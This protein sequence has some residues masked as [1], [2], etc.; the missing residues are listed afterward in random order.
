MACK[1]FAVKI[2]FAWVW[3]SGTLADK[4]KW[5]KPGMVAHNLYSSTWESEP[6]QSR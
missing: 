1:S 2:V 6:S 3:K 5:R 4:K